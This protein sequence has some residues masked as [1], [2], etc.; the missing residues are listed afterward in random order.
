MQ[1]Y[2]KR[3]DLLHTGAHKLNHALGQALLAER[4]GKRRLIAETG[5][6]QHGVASATA[7]ALLGLEVRVHMGSQDA[8]RQAANV[9]RMRLLGARVVL[10]DEGQG[11]LCDAVDAA[12]RDW[13]EDPAAHYC[14]GSALGPHPFPGMIARFQ[15]VVG[16]EAR[17]Q[18]EQQVGGG[19]DVAL[20]CVGGGSNAI[21]LFR[22]FRETG[23]E[24]VGVEAG[25]DGS[26]RAGTH[27]AR[28][29]AGAEAVLHGC[30]TRVLC[31]E[32][33]QTAPT[34]SISAGLDYPAVGPEHAH[35]AELGRA[36]YVSASDRDAL[37]AFRLLARREGILPALES[38][39]ALGH[40]ISERT[41]YRGRTVLMNLSGRGDKDL[42][43]VRRL[44][45]RGVPR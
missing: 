4:M 43:Q 6:G 2:L 42:E 30:R 11:T 39:H 27:A 31:D 21:G 19:P 22:G 35:L 28:F 38:S 41:R 17:E 25:G 16:L 36:R 12:L 29:G 44:L 40:L 32:D 8:R 26:G 1:L 15:E 5:A 7:G 37:R 34:A 3:E 14:L 24:L 9:Q 10:T 13:V 23:A 20:A 18:F 33:G 45:G